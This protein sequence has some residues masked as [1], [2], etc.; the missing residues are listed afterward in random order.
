MWRILMYGP[1]AH[2]LR[3]IR[4]SLIESGT[5][6]VAVRAPRLTRLVL[7]SG[8]IA[9]VL[10]LAVLAA[11]ALAGSEPG[12]YALGQQPGSQQP[13]SAQAGA[14]SSCDAP[15]SDVDG[16]FGVIVSGPTADV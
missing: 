6:S 2:S 10:V 5:R 16:R 4:R 14:P 9:A 11:Q 15:P 13:V 12:A 1:D 3:D 7:A 8:L